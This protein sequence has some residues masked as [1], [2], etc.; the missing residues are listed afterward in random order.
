MS[1]Q[2]VE[3][4]KLHGG[5]IV[6]LQRVEI[7]DWHAGDSKIVEYHYQGTQILDSV[8]IPGQ[9]KIVEV[10][11]VFGLHHGVRMVDFQGVQI[12]F[13]SEVQILPMMVQGGAMQMSRE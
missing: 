4:V 11:S 8:D 6:D 9:R 7:V 13:F 2:V 3:I 12:A 5:Q 1:F 10:A